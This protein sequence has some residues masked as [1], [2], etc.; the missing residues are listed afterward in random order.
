MTTRFDV[1][2]LLLAATLTGG[3]TACD[4]D[5]EGHDASGIFEA[6]EVIVSAR[7]AGEIVWLDIA[8]GDRLKA[9]STV[10]CL[11]TVQLHLKREQLAATLT[12]V[13]SRRY[14]VERQLA[15]TRQQIATQERERER[16]AALVRDKAANAKQLDD[17]E[18][19]LALLRRQLAA[20]TETL[21]NTN[22]G[23]GGEA[24]AVIA[25]IAQLDD[26]MAKARIVCP[27]TG[28][29]MAKY[30][31][32]G[33]LA[34]TGRALFKVADVDRVFLRAY[35]TAPQLT[36]LKLGQRVKVFADYGETDSREYEGTV[37]W[38]S[39]ESEFTPKT[40]QTRDERANLV[41]AV[42]VAVE[43][44][45]LIKVGMYGEVDF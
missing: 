19:Q 16:F 45:G 26:Q 39:A 34:Q 40:I 31:E 28:T 10:G 42:K 12:A 13:E 29:V 20:Q 2:T 25:Q 1:R 44:D 6:T 4:G 32:A 43:N 14:D 35:V 30:A 22:R 23:A 17:T 24:R 27:V 38:I 33:E 21:E 36:R 18:A 11:D 5:G 41:Y 7:T 8:E 37:T 3:L 15:A 9:D